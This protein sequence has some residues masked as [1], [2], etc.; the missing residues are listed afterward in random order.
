MGV[1]VGVGIVDRAGGEQAQGTLTLISHWCD[2]T[3]KQIHCEDGTVLPDVRWLSDAQNEVDSLPARER[4]AVQHVADKL[5]A[6]GERLPSPHQSAVKGVENLRELRPRGGDSP[7]RAFYR[8]TGATTFVIAAI[9]PE[10]DVDPR[11]FRKAVRA[12]VDRLAAIGGGGT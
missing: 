6:M 5:A 12:A 10:A 3:G 11:G 7:W 9:G 2:N 1:G 4:V 8:R